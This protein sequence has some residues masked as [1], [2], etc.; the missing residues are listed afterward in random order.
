M[1]SDCQAREHHNYKIIKNLYAESI[2]NRNCFACKHCIELSDDRDGCRL[3]DLIAGDSECKHGLIPIKQSCEHFEA[4]PW[5][6][7]DTYKFYTKKKEG[8]KK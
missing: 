4:V 1:L 5:E 8:D 2:K 7:T 6:E 3:C